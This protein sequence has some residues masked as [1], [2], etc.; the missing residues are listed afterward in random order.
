MKKIRK[1]RILCA[2]DY[3]RSSH[4]DVLAREAFTAVGNL[5]QK[6]RMRDFVSDFGCHLTDA[7]KYV[8][9]SSYFSK[10]TY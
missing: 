9:Y 4:I 2:V 7:V 8:M 1:I 6:K 5:L 3:D 10:L